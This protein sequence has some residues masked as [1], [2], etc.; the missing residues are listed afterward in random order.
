MNKNKTTYA[1]GSKFE[2]QLSL[3]VASPADNTLYQFW[4]MSNLA[5]FTVPLMMWEP[6][7]PIR[8]TDWTIFKN[9]NGVNGSGELSEFRLI[10]RAKVNGV[11]YTGLTILDRRLLH[12]GVTFSNLLEAS[13]SSH[14]LMIDVFHGNYYAM[15][16]LTPIWGTNP[17]NVYIQFHFTGYYL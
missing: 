12:N 11:D 2:I 5:I 13:Q 3:N 8:I 14:N 10:R 9:C 15:E 6:S 7:Q 4:P 1:S 16:W 17:T